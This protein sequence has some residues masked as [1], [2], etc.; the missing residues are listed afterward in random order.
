MNSIV[1]GLV[2]RTALRGWIEKNRNLFLVRRRM[3]EELPARY[4]RKF[5]GT[6]VLS[7]MGVRRRYLGAKAGELS[8]LTIKVSPTMRCNLKCVG[9]FAG[10]Y[11][12]AADMPVGTIESIIEQAREIGIPSVGILGG[13]PLLFP[14]LLDLLARYTDVGFYIATN[15]TLVTRDVVSRLKSLPHVITAFS[16]DGFEEINDRFRGRGVFRRIVAAMELM[17]EA[18][19]AFGFSTT[20]HRENMSEVVSGRYLDFMIDKGCLF[21]AFLPYVPVG[22]EPAFELVCSEGEVKEY[23]RELDSLTAER[24]ILVLK[25]GY[26]DGTFLNSGCGAGH[27]LHIT[28]GGDVEPCNGIQFH[29]DNINA[30]RLLDIFMS[31]YFC[32]I[33]G[34]HP[35]DRR[36]C[37]V[38]A[39]PEAV[40]EVVRKHGAEETHSGAIAHL[41]SY[42]AAAGVTETH[43]GDPDLA[44]KGPGVTI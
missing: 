34:L 5:Y 22:S 44:T 7:H 8:P 37:L 18:R 29:K 10:N 27:T 15:G 28:S 39:R 40:L 30:K 32:D 1:R 9:C 19:I 13:E 25:E 26:S 35:K 2:E 21:G 11:S 6:W 33:R 23:Y 24:A 41:S 43:I 3:V 12:S 4:R 17:K 16:V 20:V 38:V 36:E 42:I 31:P 14:P